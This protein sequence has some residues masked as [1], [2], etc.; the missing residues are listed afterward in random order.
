MKTSWTAAALLCCSNSCR[1][2]RQY[3]GKYSEFSTNERLQRLLTCLRRRLRKARPPSRDC[4]RLR[5]GQLSEGQF[6]ASPRPPGARV[7]ACP[8]ASATAQATAP[9]RRRP[10]CNG[11]ASR[12]RYREV[13]GPANTSLTLEL[14]TAVSSETAQV[15]DPV[16]ARLRQPLDRW[17]AT[18]CCRPA[19]CCSG[20][21]IDVAR[22]GRVQGRSR[23][24]FRFTELRARWRTEELQNQPRHVRGRSHQG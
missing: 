1:V 3:A 23:L 11:L 8:D 10:P 14:L 7:A 15:E 20:N 6:D 18:R 12:P 9:L 16:R 2:R 4:R 5:T 22:A 24:V 13:D 17:M 19:L 21:V